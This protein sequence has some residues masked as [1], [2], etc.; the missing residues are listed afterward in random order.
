[1]AIGTTAAIIGSAVIGAGA[2]AMSASK[3]SKA[4]SK[5]TAAQSAG[6]A[7]ALA[8]QERARSE[9][10]A[11][12]SPIYQAGL[13]AMQARNALL[14]IGGQP[15]QQQLPTPQPNAMTQFQ[16]GGTG[17]GLMYEGFDGPM[18]GYGMREG[19][20]RGFTGEPM[21]GFFTMGS[22]APQQQQAAQA[23]PTGQTPA[24]A[25][26]T[27]RNS[28]GYQ[29]RLN[30]GMDAVN[31]G[32]AGAGTLQSGAAMKA[33][34]DYGQGMA[35]AEFG[36]YMGYLGEQQGLASGAANAMSGVN[37]AY[38]NNAGNLAIANGQNLSN[39]AVARANNN[40]ALIQ[41][42][43]GAF[44]GAL[45]GLGGFSGGNA[46]STNGGLSGSF[47]NTTGGRI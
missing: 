17:Q 30:Q 32:Y 42:I 36:N 21:G 29:F 8:A 26:D 6:N 31:S 4:I 3:N 2:S 13:P 45:G 47:I 23:A 16:P 7:Q 22:V 15:A 40:N 44:S 33:I 19:A 27:F 11:L 5:S 35:S 46:L 9:N 12:Q 34:N 18:G 39:S 1:M 25:F 20:G 14:G 41:G 24:N 43:G 28:T 10:M 37:S 38:A